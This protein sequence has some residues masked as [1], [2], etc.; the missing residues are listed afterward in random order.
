MVELSLEA[1]VLIRRLVA[2][3]QLPDSAGLRLCTGAGSRSLSLALATAPDR[4]DVVLT[5]NGASLFVSPTAAQRVAHQTLRA[6]VQGRPA[7]FVD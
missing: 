4:H 3:H 7:F 6:Q 2:D 5:R 1:A